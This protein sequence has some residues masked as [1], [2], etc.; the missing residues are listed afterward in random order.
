MGSNPVKGGRLE[1]GVWKTVST[2]WGYC[3]VTYRT[4]GSAF[5]LEARFRPIGGTQT[6]REGQVFVLQRRR[7]RR[8]CLPFGPGRTL[9]HHDPGA[10]PLISRAA[11]RS[12]ATRTTSTP[13]S[14][15]SRRR[16]VAGE[17]G[18]WH[19]GG[20]GGLVDDD[21]RNVRQVGKASQETDASQV[22]GEA[23]SRGVVPMSIKVVVR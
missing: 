23:K 21:V 18:C 4:L 2:G 10:P 11:G 8:A 15:P 6:L 12:C 19:A 14:F 22:H 17:G 1:P 7:I 3:S 20:G 5:P 9:E 16:R 13:S